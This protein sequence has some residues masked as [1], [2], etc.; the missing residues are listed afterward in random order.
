MTYF[1]SQ[2][3]EVRHMFSIKKE[4]LCLMLFFATSA[5][6]QIAFFLKKSIE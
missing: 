4:V 2:D 3:D 5:L 6:L 1:I